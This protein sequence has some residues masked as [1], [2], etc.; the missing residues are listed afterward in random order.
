MTK[1]FLVAAMILAG[2]FTESSAQIDGLRFHVGL[3]AFDAEI[4]DGRRIRVNEPPPDTYNYRD[5]RFRSTYQSMFAAVSAERS[6]NA[7]F[8]LSAGL[9]Y[10]R[11]SGHL[12]ANAMHR[13]PEYF[14][15][16]Y[17]EDGVVTEFLRVREF[18]ENTHY[19]GIPV[20]FRFSPMT[21]NF[22]IIVRT[23]AQVNYKIAKSGSV[24]FLDQQM[25]QYEDEIVDSFTEAEALN[26]IVV[27]GAGLSYGK[28][29]KPAYGV[30]VAAP[31][32]YANDDAAGMFTPTAG[33]G[34]SFFIKIPLKSASND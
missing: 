34:F 14:Y 3:Y 8:S 10:A 7:K 6:L 26:L 16:R 21:S 5:D 24:E 12:E 17:R 29:G 1:L 11:M 28:P 32:V 23:G 22:K 20:D 31:C 15:Y 18:Q 13:G 30:E 25:N 19:I 27:V 2:T 9:Q 4:K 33:A